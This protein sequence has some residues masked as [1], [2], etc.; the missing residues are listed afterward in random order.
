MAAP[1]PIELPF[2]APVSP[3]LWALS[4]SCKA[5]H[6]LDQTGRFAICGWRGVLWLGL[7]RDGGLG[8]RNLTE[9]ERAKR[10][11]VCVGELA[12]EER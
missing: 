5:L 2:D 3:N 8:G 12:A 9:H 6:K 10:C 7:S 11:P 1:Q 4:Y